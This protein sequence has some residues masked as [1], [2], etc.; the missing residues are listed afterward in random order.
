MCRSTEF[1]VYTRPSALCHHCECST[2]T[3][4]S[5]TSTHLTWKDYS[6]YNSQNQSTRHALLRFQPSYTHNIRCHLSELLSN[7]RVCGSF[8]LCETFNVT[9]IYPL[10]MS[11]TRPILDTAIISERYCR[12]A[13]NVSYSEVTG[14]EYW[15][16]IWRFLMLML[17]LLLL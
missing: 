9:N 11:H 4:G 16:R 10:K 15:P 13:N 7:C 5:G 17:L 3:V 1:S 2:F 8:T 12:V 6:K 14:F